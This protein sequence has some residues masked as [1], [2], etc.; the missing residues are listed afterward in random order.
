MV[1]RCEQVHAESRS[2]TRPGGPCPSHDG[3]SC[4]YRDQWMLECGRRN[5]PYR[6]GTG[7]PQLKLCGEVRALFSSLPFCSRSV[8]GAG[9][10]LR[11]T[12]SLGEGERERERLAR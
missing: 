9:V 6:T 11:T 1:I 5:E 12:D 4:L 7:L 2:L 8:L 3:I 10:T